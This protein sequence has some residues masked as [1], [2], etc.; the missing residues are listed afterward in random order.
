MGAHTSILQCPAAASILSSN[1][2][3]GTGQWGGPQHCTQSNGPGRSRVC[4]CWLTVV[5]IFF[6]E[7][8]TGQTPA[9]PALTTGGR[10]GQTS[11]NI[12]TRRW[13]EETGGRRQGSTQEQLGWRNRKRLAVVEKQSNKEATSWAHQ[14]GGGAL[15][16][17]K[18]T[19]GLYCHVVSD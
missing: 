10:T 14:H 12:S 9:H 3:S 4:R 8:N 7:D 19:L 11:S 1:M 5:L 13:R 18:K 15:F 2:T 17:G 6:G 16:L